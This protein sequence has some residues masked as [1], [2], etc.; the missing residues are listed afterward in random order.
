M[1][2]ITVAPQQKRNIEE[3]GQAYILE[4]VAYDPIKITSLHNYNKQSRVY[5]KSCDW[6]TTVGELPEDNGRIQPDM[7]P[8]CVKKGE[9]GF[10]RSTPKSPKE[11]TG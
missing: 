8:D 9:M 3:L 11:A 4:G 10:I 7:C 2:K 1:D 5:C 6:E